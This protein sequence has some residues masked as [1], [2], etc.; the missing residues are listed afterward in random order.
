[1]STDLIKARQQLSQIRGLLQTGKALPAIQA[2]YS[3]L[4]IILKNPLMKS[5]KEEFAH[6][7]ENAVYA[8][9]VDPTVQRIHPVQIQ[10]KV[11]NERQLYDEIRQLFHEVDS[12]VRGSVQEAVKNLNERR[13]KLLE[14]GTAFLEHGEVDKARNTFTTLAKEN[15]DDPELYG[16]IGQ[17]FLKFGEYADAIKYL[18]IAITL[19]PD[20][21]DLYN[22]IGIALRKTGDFVTAEQYYL[23]A[24]SHLGRDPNLFFNMGRLYL[25]W[26][27]WDD[28]IKVATAA[29]KM[30]SDFV[31]A[32]KLVDYAKAQRD[33]Y[34]R[35]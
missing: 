8:I 34:K 26:K 9:G 10:Y 30:K 15:K 13:Q 24:A 1:M 2:L 32:Q 20:L 4:L 23:K 31:E 3:A 6:M 21:V 14:E 18:D 11:G 27:K 12:D 17:S 19:N 25:D 5:E 28:A 29:L 7:V 16:Q 22:G 33:K 35:R